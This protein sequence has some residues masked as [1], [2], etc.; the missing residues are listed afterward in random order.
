MGD[1]DGRTQWKP[2]DRAWQRLAAENSAWKGADA[3]G[4]DSQKLMESPGSAA[5]GALNRIGPRPPRP[6]TGRYGVQYGRRDEKIGIVQRAVQNSQPAQRGFVHGV[7][8]AIFFSPT[9]LLEKAIRPSLSL[10][11]AL[12]PLHR[13]LGSKKTDQLNEQPS[14]RA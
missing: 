6:Q 5:Q 11:P 13:H 9:K 8:G 1:R 14:G 2:N 3:D 10:F 4:R 7:S 12:S